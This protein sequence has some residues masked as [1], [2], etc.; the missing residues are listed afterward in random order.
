MKVSDLQEENPDVTDN[1]YTEHFLCSWWLRLSGANMKTLY[2]LIY[3]V[4]THHKNFFFMNFTEVF[5]KFIWKNK[6]AQLAKK[7]FQKNK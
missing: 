2:E 7:I 5:L 1:K 6:H 4:N 3:K